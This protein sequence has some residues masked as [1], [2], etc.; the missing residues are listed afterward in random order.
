[1][2]ARNIRAFGGPAVREGAVPV[3][4]LVNRAL[5]CPSG[6]PPP[7]HARHPFHTNV[8]EQI[9]GVRLAVRTVPLYRGSTSLQSPPAATCSFHL[10][11]PRTLDSGEHTLELP[12]GG[13]H[14]ALSMMRRM[15]SSGG[16]RYS[17]GLATL[18]HVRF[19][20]KVQLRRLSPQ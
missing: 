13:R 6:K 20:I 8:H 7:E 16:S 15:G 17:R 3:S 14:A 5:S 10:T 4:V 1:M 2:W 11:H 19:Q 18:L 9:Y 12:S